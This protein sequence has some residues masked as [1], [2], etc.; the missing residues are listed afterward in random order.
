MNIDQ[1]VQGQRLMILLKGE[2]G[3][4][5]SIQAG[6][7]PNV[8]FF[9]FDNRIG[10]VVQ[11]YRSKG[12]KDIDFDYYPIDRLDRAHDKLLLWKKNGCPY[13]AI[14]MDTTTTLIG[15]TFH[16]ITKMKGAIAASKSKD[17]YGMAVDM[18]F[19]KGTALDDYK[20]LLSAV[21]Q[22]LYL[23]K[24]ISDAH[25]I[26]NGH[27]QAKETTDMAGNTKLMRYLL[28]PGQ[29]AQEIP[30]HFDEIYHMDIEDS[31][32]V[33]EKPRRLILTESNG[34]DFARTALGLP[35]ILDVTSKLLYPTLLEILPGI[36]KKVEKPKGPVTL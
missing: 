35:R 32:K 33:G 19:I 25:V 9:D 31:I 22:L 1:F 12:R 7:F 16:Y 34:K 24:D 4:G 17:S 26:W 3:V 2:T 6:S 5:K 36:E 8:Y 15:A 10:S 11:Y 30:I 20:Y 13:N 29:T 14:V 21:K 18:G 23:T 27:L 28:A